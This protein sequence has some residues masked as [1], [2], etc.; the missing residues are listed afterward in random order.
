MRLEHRK[1]AAYKWQVALFDEEQRRHWENLWFA[2]AMEYDQYI[3]LAK[4]LLE[5]QGTEYSLA[6]VRRKGPVFKFKRKND[7]L[8][9]MMCRGNIFNINKL[10][11]A[12]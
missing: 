6:T 8:W 12:D 5:K 7:A 1:T 2:R 9:F 4:E 3:K 11:G 10:R